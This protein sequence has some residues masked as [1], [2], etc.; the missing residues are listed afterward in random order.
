MPPKTVARAT[1]AFS[2]LTLIGGVIAQGL[3]ANA[4]SAHAT[5][6][7]RRRNALNPRLFR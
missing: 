2:L 5:P 7:P 6:S 1:G 3:I 4:S